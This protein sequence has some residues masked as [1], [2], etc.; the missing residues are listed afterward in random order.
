MAF[1]GIRESVMAVYSIPQ[2]A[3]SIPKPWRQWRDM[4]CCVFYST[5][6]VHSR[7]RRILMDIISNFIELAESIDTYETA[8]HGALDCIKALIADMMKRGETL[9]E[10]DAYLSSDPF[11]MI[12]LTLPPDL[13]RAALK[14]T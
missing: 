4:L 1:D 14:I 10:I 13:V 5:T 8:M 12:G 6:V 9:A 2:M 7:K 3:Q 11:K